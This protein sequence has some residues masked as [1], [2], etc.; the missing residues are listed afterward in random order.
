[1]GTAGGGLLGAG[2]GGNGAL[3]GGL[4]FGGSCSAR[5]SALALALERRRDER[6]GGL[7][8][9]TEVDCRRSVVSVEE[10]RRSVVDFEVEME[11]RFPPLRVDRRL[12]GEGVRLL[13]DVGKGESVSCWRRLVG[14]GKRFSLSCASDDMSAGVGVGV[15][16]AVEGG[17]KYCA[18]GLA[19]G[20]AAELVVVFDAVV[21]VEDMLWLACTETRFDVGGD[22]L[23]GRGLWNTEARFPPADDCDDVVG[24]AVRGD[25]G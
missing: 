20:D 6:I 22:T 11:A 4:G 13:E 9:G 5:P 15:M 25:C 1:M 8:M 18:E 19:H 23:R 14:R 16:P 24:G 7:M 3:G 17:V 12:F 10:D 21:D 2:G